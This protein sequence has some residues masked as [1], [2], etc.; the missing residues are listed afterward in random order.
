[1]VSNYLSIRVVLITNPLLVQID[2]TVPI[3]IE[4]TIFCRVLLLMHSMAVNFILWMMVENKGA[5]LKNNISALM[6]IFLLV[7]II[8]FG[9]VI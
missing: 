6:V 7:S 4:I 2:L 9:T 3:D 5:L 1:M 8:Y